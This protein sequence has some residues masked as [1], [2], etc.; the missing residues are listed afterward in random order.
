M[1]MVI[2]F[3]PTSINFEY[4]LTPL[5]KDLHPERAVQGDFQTSVEVGLPVATQAARRRV[6]AGHLVRRTG[7]SWSGP[8]ALTVYPHTIF[9]VFDRDE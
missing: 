7:R 6:G 5:G 1:S 4:S 2:P 8:R 9:P 3:S